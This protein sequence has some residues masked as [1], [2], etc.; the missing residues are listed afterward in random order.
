M[1]FLINL[2]INFCKPPI[3]KEFAK[4]S[5]NF[6]KFL[7]EKYMKKILIIH[8][9]LLTGL[10][11]SFGQVI[12]PAQIQQMKVDDLTD[13]QVRQVVVEMKK[14]NIGLHQ[15]N[16]F[17]QQ[18]GIPQSEVSKLRSRIRSLNL[19]KEFSS[20]PQTESEETSRGI[21]MVK[22]TNDEGG[23]VEAVGS[24]TI[25]FGSDLF[26]N[27]NLTFEPNLR[28]PTP[29]NYRLAAGDEVMIDVYGYSE[30]QHSLK[31]SPEGYVRIPNIGPVYVN[32]L[33]MEEAKTRITKQLGTIYSGIRSGNTFVQ[34]T[35]GSIRSIQVLL[36]GEV[37][38]P[39]TYTLPSL[40]SIANALYVSG[41]PNS[42]GSFRAIQVIRN[43]NI[44]ATFDLYDFITKGDLTNN[45]ILQ[46]QDIIKI[47]PYKTRVT[48]EG[49][50]K[51]PAIFEVKEGETLE[52]VLGYAGG[53][54]ELAY[55]DV[56]RASRIASKEREIITVSKSEIGGF[57]L[58]PGDRFFVDAILDRFSNRVSITGAV[59]HPGDYA[60]EKSMTILDLIKKADGLM[61][62]ASTS[63]GIIRRMKE[64][65]TPSIINFNVEDVIQD[66]Q[67]IFLQRED[68]VVIFSKLQLQEKFKVKIDGLVNN[69]GYYD[70]MDSMKLEDLV[71][72]A[73]GLREAASLKRV[74]ISRRIRG[75][76]Y[77]PADSQK[78]IVQQFEIR[79]DLRSSPEASEFMLQPFDEIIIRKSPTYIEQA[80]VTIDGEVVYPGGYVLNSRSQRISDL[81]SRAGG[82][83]PESY[84]EGAVLLRKTFTN[85]S[86]SALLS[87]KLNVFSSKQGDTSSLSQLEN[88]ILR[89]EQ[90]LNIDLQ[91]IIKNPGS[92]YDL[93]LEEGDVIKVPKKLQTVQIF[94]EIY[95]PKKVRYVKNMGFREY[96][97]N[98]GG[99]TASALKRRSYVI[100]PNGEVKSTKKAFFFNT[101]PKV[102]PGSEIYVPSRKD[103]RGINTGEA[104]GLTAGIASIALVLVTILDKIK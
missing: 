49:Q 12:D 79:N 97:R 22:M 20:A 87:Y 59:F 101:Y 21:D 84:P 98:A 62:I 61:E 9:L 74:E 99:Y 78:A 46:D 26:T 25:I 81:L 32:G 90:L 96:I 76:D 33:T 52:T 94:G 100:Y 23:K 13:E 4:D 2:P 63:R 53:Y 39:G 85:S 72:I 18:K 36:I 50:V 7:S 14:N 77:M 5:Q 35:L 15:L 27:K 64:D 8:F 3:G 88:A 82:L 41:G 10:C 68:S 29:T 95:F 73:G 47:N 80:S 34:V 54:T 70:F 48:L 28:M 71:L 102:R 1:L 67:K 86:D 24:K 45:I 66:K 91:A 17:A 51:R 58:H 104:I 69:A 83:K 30:V 93:F 11:S 92:K 65:Y 16:A 19:D 40:A 55:R 89:K 44:T 43:G 37:A 103:K 75:R 42:N 57:A 38:R 6:E 56:I 31:V 60:L